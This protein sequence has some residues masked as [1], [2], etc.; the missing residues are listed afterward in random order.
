M[1]WNPLTIVMIYRS[2]LVRWWLTYQ[3]MTYKLGDMKKKT[4]GSTQIQ[5]ATKISNCYL[6]TR[7]AQRWYWRCHRV[8]LRNLFGDIVP[9]FFGTLLGI[10]VCVFHSKRIY[11]FPRNVF[12]RRNPK[13]HRPRTFINSSYILK[14]ASF[15]NYYHYWEQP[16]SPHNNKH[17][18]WSS[19]KLITIRFFIGPASRCRYIYIC[20]IFVRTATVWTY[21]NACDCRTVIFMHIICFRTHAHTRSEPCTRNR[22]LN[23]FFSSQHWWMRGWMEWSQCFSHCGTQNEKDTDTNPQPIHFTVSVHSHLNNNNLPF[24]IAFSLEFYRSV[25][26]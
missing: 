10:C 6:S 17:N 25:Q 14:H 2:M 3:M 5:K 1:H 8:E 13:E 12:C 4:W 16:F 22:G 24:T 9:H 15:F 11:N 23:F 18:H 7:T 26:Q 20:V 21:V 19:S